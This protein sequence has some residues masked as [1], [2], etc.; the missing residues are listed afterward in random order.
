MMG[1][2]YSV[3]PCPACGE[4]AAVLVGSQPKYASEDA[5]HAALPVAT[6]FIY[7]CKCGRQYLHEQPS[8][9]VSQ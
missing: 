2:T 6:V 3:P 5:A 9:A 8:A 7:R 1:D 4:L